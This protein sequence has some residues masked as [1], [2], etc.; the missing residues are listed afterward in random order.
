MNAI[1]VGL[2]YLIKGLSIL[3]AVLFAAGII[4]IVVFGWSDSNKEMVNEE[5]VLRRMDHEIAETSTTAYHDTCMASKGYRLVG[6]CY[7]GTLIAK[8]PFCFA[9]A[10]QFW[11]K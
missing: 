10:W 6:N 2:G 3:L 8:P 7:T 9:P 4:L 5:C 1:L 11:K